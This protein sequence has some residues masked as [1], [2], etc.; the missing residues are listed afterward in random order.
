M[1]PSGEKNSLLFV[2]KFPGPDDLS[3]LVNGFTH[4]K[5]LRI[6]LIFPKE[7]SLY[8]SVIPGKIG[9]GEAVIENKKAEDRIPICAP[10]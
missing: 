7:F 6:S 2:Y 9:D 4:T 3:I 1:L 5:K 8:L 10:E